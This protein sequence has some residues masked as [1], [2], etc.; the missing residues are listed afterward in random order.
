MTDF[1]LVGLREMIERLDHLDGRADV[2]PALFLVERT[3][4]GEQHVIG[5]EERNAANRR[6]AR[7][8]E[9][10]VAVKAFE[11]VERTLLELLQD[12]RVVLIRCARAELVPAVRDAA[13]EIRD[14]A[15]EMM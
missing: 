11:I 4:G 1:L 10:R 3:I 5:A 15:A 12:Q 7:A 9:R 8:G 14:D 6:S 13:L 2:A